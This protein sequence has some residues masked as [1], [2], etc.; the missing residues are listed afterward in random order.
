MRKPVTFF[1]P[2]RSAFSPKSIGTFTKGSVYTAIGQDER[3]NTFRIEQDDLGASMWES[4]DCFIMVDLGSIRYELNKALSWQ[5]GAYSFEDM[6]DDMDSLT[7][8]E[9]VIAK[10]IFHVKAVLKEKA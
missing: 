6:V 2:E 1:Y 3:T 8:V 4:R 9:Q 10:E 7:R 5:E